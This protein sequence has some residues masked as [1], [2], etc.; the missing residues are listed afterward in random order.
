METVIIVLQGLIFGCL[1]H[2]ERKTSSMGTKVDYLWKK[3]VNGE[4]NPRPS[5]SR[6][7]GLHKK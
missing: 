1:I 3:V 5:R 4:N 6:S 2:M 7:R